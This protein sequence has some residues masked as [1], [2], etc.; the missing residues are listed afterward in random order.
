MAWKQLVK[1][2]LD[3]KKLIAKDGA[4]NILYDWCGWCLAVTQAAF[5]ITK[6][7]YPSAIAAWND[8]PHKYATT[9]LDDIPIGLYIPM[10]FEGG[11]YGHIVVAY[12]E[13]YEKIKI[14]S[15]PYKSKPKL[16]PPSYS[17]SFLLQTL[18]CPPSSSLLA[19]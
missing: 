14:W 6:K 16:S 8:N 12:R 11:K 3:D 1:P 17:P 5:G 13:S 15:S 4:G 19:I 10:F 9:R 7:K 2:Y 18:Y